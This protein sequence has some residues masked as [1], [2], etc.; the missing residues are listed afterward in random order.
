MLQVLKVSKEVVI[1][2]T[3]GGAMPGFGVRRSWAFAFKLIRSMHMAPQGGDQLIRNLSAARGPAAGRGI[4][5][6][7]MGS[8][9]R[10]QGGKTTRR[11]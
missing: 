10:R 11:P 3:Q 9:A 6:A 4:P 1:G 7:C 8:H 2:C 5:L